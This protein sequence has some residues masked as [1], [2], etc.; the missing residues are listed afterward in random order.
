MSGRSWFVASGGKQQGPYSEAQFRD[1][2][3]QGTVTPDTLVWS[4]GMSGWQKAGDIPGLLSSGSRPPPFPGSA[5]PQTDGSL[6]GGGPLSATFGVWALFGRSLLLFIGNL[7]V[8]PA[9]WLV[10]GFYRWMIAHI[11]V[12]QRPNLAF[13]GKPGDI[14]YVFVILA[15]YPYA[16]FTNS[17][18]LPFILIAVEAVLTWMIVRWIV[19]NISSDG[20]QLPLTFEGSVWGYIGWYLLFVVSSITIIGWAWVATALM[21]WICRNIAGTRRA[22]VFNGSGWGV[23]WRTLVFS[24]CSI[25]IIP[26]PWILRWYASW[27]VSQF[28]VVAKAA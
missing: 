8:I 13:T 23:L 17:A 1:L 25:L 22:V 12:P 6:A 19:V 9:P 2:I 18:I 21:R 7:F 10:T 28:A 26:I 3:A 16:V 15:L 5:A 14:W 24:L 11:H 4:E 27:Y 20:H